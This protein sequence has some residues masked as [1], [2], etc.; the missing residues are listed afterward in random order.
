[1]M[2]DAA[3]ELRLR[4]DDAR[5]LCVALGLQMAPRAS[6]QQAMVCCPEHAENTPSCSVRVAKDGTIAVRCHG[7]GWSADALGLIAQVRSLNVE[8]EFSE[9]LRAA[10][11]IAGPS[12]TTCEPRHARAH[13]EPETIGEETYDRIWTHVLDA[14]SPTR[15]VAPN[16][17]GYLTWRGIFADADAVGI[18]GLP[19][20]ADT[21]LASL[22]ST[23][24]RH[25]LERAGVLRQGLEVLDWLAWA[26]CIPWRDR[27]GRITCVQRRRIDDGRPKYRSP[28]GR[29]PRAPFGVELLK[30]A[31]AFHGPDAEVVVVEGAL[32]CLARRRI[33]RHQSERAAVIGVYS[34]SSP[35]VGLPVDLLSGRRIVLALDNDAAGEAACSRIADA[36]RDVAAELVR[37]RPECG[38]DWLEALSGD[39]A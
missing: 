29:A 4:L 26:L 1:M 5:A 8:R 22:F 23:F 39:V 7:C 28:A 25:H 34:A 37:E 31:L 2:P 24:E 19:S 18:R 38:K 32:D 15:S 20:R 10:A 17:A 36:L 13:R 33:A 21:L 30:D 6:A 11:H 12:V 3:R 35:T 16:V 14:C 27:F 9:V